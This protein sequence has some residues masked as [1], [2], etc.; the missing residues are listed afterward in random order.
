MDDVRPVA[1]SDAFDHLVSEEAQ[2]FGLINRESKIS[3]ISKFE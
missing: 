3:E 2:S 1:E